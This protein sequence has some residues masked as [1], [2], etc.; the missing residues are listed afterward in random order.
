MT[1][2]R[3]RDPADACP[4]DS[5][6]FLCG[7]N[8]GRAGDILIPATSCRSGCRICGSMNGRGALGKSIR[9]VHQS[10]GESIQ[11]DMRERALSDS[12]IL[13]PGRTSCIGFRTRMSEKMPVRRNH[14]GAWVNP[15][16]QNLILPIAG[17]PPAMTRASPCLCIPFHGKHDRCP[18]CAATWGRAR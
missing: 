7:G 2:N 10:S 13:A 6:L 17:Y 3:G 18:G 1:S 16:H 11:K 8:T 12:N 9:L 4:R 14:Q 5:W 15:G